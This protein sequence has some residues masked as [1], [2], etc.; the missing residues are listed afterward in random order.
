MNRSIK[1]YRLKNILFGGVKKQVE[2]INDFINKNYNTVT[3]E[4]AK[5]I[6][7][8]NNF[9]E[10]LGLLI[11]N[12]I[13]DG[14]SKHLFIENLKAAITRSIMLNIPLLQNIDE[15]YQIYNNLNELGNIIYREPGTSL[16]KDEEKDKVNDLFEEEGCGD[17]ILFTVRFGHII[18]PTVDLKAMHMLLTMKHTRTYI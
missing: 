8:F 5:S 13:I 18:E 3:D 11:K 15:H 14:S 16:D 4:N 6:M 1:K 17:K 7:G 12:E 10:Q 9:D 2:S